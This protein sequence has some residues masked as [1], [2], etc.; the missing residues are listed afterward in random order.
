M[1]KFK[2]IYVFIF[3]LAIFIGFSWEFLFTKGLE[4]FLYQSFPHLSF[5]SIR[6]DRESWII[7]Q[8][9]SLGS[10]E[11]IHFK[12]SHALFN[13][14]IDLFN[15]EISL[16]LT[17]DD[18][19]IIIHD[20]DPSFSIKY[21]YENRGFFSLRKEIVF[22][23]GRLILGKE[24]YPFHGQILADSSLEGSFQVNFNENKS[25]NFHFV[26]DALMDWQY[27]IECQDVD[28]FYL[29][30]A[31]SYCFSDLQSLKV[32]DGVLRGKLSILL[33]DQ[34]R[35]RIYGEANLTH[36][37]FEHMPSGMGARI[38]ELCFYQKKDLRQGSLI[39]YE[40]QTI[41][42]SSKKTG[43]AEI[44][45][46]MGGI[47]FDEN[48]QSKIYFQGIYD[49]LGQ[50]FHLKV[51]GFASLPSNDKA[52]LDLAWELKDSQQYLTKGHL[53][54][55]E[56]NQSQYE[57][58]LYLKDFRLQYATPLETLWQKLFP[59]LR[60][61]KICGGTVNVS[62]EAIVREKKIDHVM[63]N[64]IN[65]KDFKTY[66]QPLQ[67]SLAAD[68]SGKVDLNVSRYSLDDVNHL[69][70]TLNEGKINYSGITIDD[71]QS[72]ISISRGK[73]AKSYATAK[74]E[75]MI[76]TIEGDESSLK[77]NL[78]GMLNHLFRCIHD[79]KLQ[80][81]L[82]R[83]FD[84]HEI[85]L[86]VALKHNLSP[87]NKSD[88]NSFPLEDRKNKGA[89]FFNMAPLF[90]EPLVRASREKTTSS[91]TAII[92][93]KLGL[94]Q[95]HEWVGRAK[96]I[97]PQGFEN[98][99]SFGF[100]FPTIFHLPHK[101]WFRG[102][103]LPL[104]K[105]VA[106]FF[107][108]ETSIQLTGL[109]NFSGFFE[110]QLVKVVYE[111]QQVNLENE[112]FV[113]EIPSAQKFL[114]YFYD[115]G[116]GKHFGSL[117]VSNA[118]YLEKNSGLLFTDINAEVLVEQNEIHIPTF[119]TFCHGIFMAGSIDI[120]LKH[121]HKGCFDI[122]IRPQM[123]QGKVTQVQSFFSHFQKQPFFFRIP[124]EGD[125]ALQHNASRIHFAFSSN[126]YDVDAFLKGSLSDGLLLTHQTNVSLQALSLNF[127]YDKKA[128]SLDFSE[129]QATMLVGDPDKAEE[130]AVVGEKIHFTDYRGNKAVF[131]LWIGDKKRDMIRLAGE[132]FTASHDVTGDSIQFVLDRNLSHFGNVH[133]NTFHLILKDWCQVQEFHL[134][135]DLKLSSFLKDLKRFSKTGF[136]FL[137]PRVLKQLDDIKKA[138]GIFQID[139][140]YD[141]LL[142]QLNYH[143][144]GENVEIDAYMFKN[145]LLDGKKS[146]A[147]WIIDQLV[148]DNL[149]IAADIKRK[150]ESWL[151]NFLGLQY[152][153][154]VLMGLQGEYFDNSHLLN[155]KINLLEINIETLK[156]WPKAQKFLTKYPLEGYLRASGHFQY[157][158]SQN[159]SHGKLEI[160]L[161]ASLKNWKFKDIL[162]DGIPQLS[163]HYI[164]DQSLVI[165]K[166]KSGLKSQQD[167]S[168]IAD[169]ILEKASYDLNQDSFSL[170]NLDFHISSLNLQQVVDQLV[171]SFPLASSVVNKFVHCKRN[172]DLMGS[173]SVD[174]AD[175]HYT[176][177]L[178]LKDG[179]YHFLNK[180]IA[181]SNFLLE[182]DPREL[183]LSV[184]CQADTIPFWVQYKSSNHEE[185]IFTEEPPGIPSQNPLTIKC[186]CAENGCVIDEIIGQFHGMDVALHRDETKK[187][188]DF[189]HLLKGEIK[190]NAQEVM[191]LLPSELKATVSNWKIGSGFSLKGLWEL[192]PSSKSDEFFKAYFK[193]QLE[194]KKWECKGYQFEHLFAEVEAAPN[195]IFMNDIS[196]RDRAGNLQIAELHLHKPVRENWSLFLSKCEIQ[197]F[198]PSILEK[199]DESKKTDASSLKN[200]Y[201]VR[202]FIL[203]DLQGNM[204]N[205]K[206][207]HGRGS[208]EF[209]N[210][211]KK[212][213]NPPLFAIP[214]EILNRLG[215]DMA[216]LTPVVGTISYEVKEGKIYLTKLKD[217]YSQGKMSRFYLSSSSQQSYV[218]FDGKLNI[219]LKMRYY[220]L[221]FKLAEL[222]TVT[223]QG[224]LQKPVYTL[225]KQK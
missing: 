184:K 99:I 10:S 59:S 222:F 130:Y 196:V 93:D 35:P 107:L 166:V 92:D 97:G 101:G 211:P 170:T 114:D 76:A 69:D 223:I 136:L 193:G 106:P 153:D 185:L 52:A 63:I 22:N 213:S 125:I 142:S 91:Q 124:L 60:E 171:L 116:T 9:F 5:K 12:A 48:G 65:I 199:D 158:T 2:K 98:E 140:G 179:D 17:V 182:Y 149:S 183:A 78:K 82:S 197:D 86:N 61:F 205:K 20:P 192:R 4:F 95:N 155:G 214:G 25:I 13:Y 102:E 57:A 77:L 72:F 64:Q 94:N 188:N 108:K 104:E 173:L 150:P 39:F 113:L 51:N 209:V 105:Y 218:D 191:A 194:G 178:K 75:T 147:S 111:T 30:H 143:V 80:V 127:T 14:E 122:D 109:G 85:N 135:A 128:N 88:S 208:L 1:S 89:I 46:L 8:P 139:V 38:K 44:R 187:T 202:K 181:L 146:N 144:S 50:L 3:L 21:L 221:F 53:K 15:K 200:T 167:G 175:P 195:R 41:D 103:N 87:M 112:N 56:T 36:L 210:P 133:P 42:A 49:N 151:I 45:N 132:T 165:G 16:Y 62:A 33:K 68:I 216:V 121:L 123:M 162:F 212:T 31:L 81:S 126:D 201:V 7:D 119:E 11:A 34:Q 215:L 160:L 79:E 66:Y 28:F 217:A 43:I 19:E 152:E 32:Y 219:K 67:L 129:I 55:I 58:K 164:S 224:T 18:P 73:L 159:N 70:L 154:S 110:K 37:S 203:E 40:D 26:R 190:F 148:L 27:D 161:N 156:K 172:E 115:Y 131:D 168:K 176:I 163:L 134:I 90:S 174:Y 138:E 47:Y 157:T 100:D 180:K 204:G 96:I 71:I 54:I 24:K 23:Q 177:K 206:S 120:G 29:H 189:V 141:E 225:Q 118:S 117:P 145:V 207:F 220:N 198:K 84:K 6:H 74:L 169:L 186:Q 83:A 137:T